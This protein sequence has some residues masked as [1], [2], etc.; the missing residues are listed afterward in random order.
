MRQGQLPLCP[1][2]LDASP[3]TAT[4]QRSS[5]TRNTLLDLNLFS[6][7]RCSSWRKQSALGIP[8]SS[9]SLWLSSWVMRWLLWWCSP[10]AQEAGL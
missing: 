5:S 1:R 8:K 6:F 3:G 9:P 2:G 4:T 10:K 7:T